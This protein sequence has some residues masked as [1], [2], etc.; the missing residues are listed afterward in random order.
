MRISEPCE[1][2]PTHF[3][4]DILEISIQFYESFHKIEPSFGKKIFVIVAI[5]T[6]SYL[7]GSIRILLDVVYR[8]HSNKSVGQAGQVVNPRSKVW[9]V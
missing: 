6:F 4:R 5:I 1:Y 7:S 3:W 8:I 9:T 2:D